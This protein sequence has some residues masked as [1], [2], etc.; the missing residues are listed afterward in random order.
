MKPEVDIEHITFEF[1][2]EELTLQIVEQATPGW[3]I[4][5]LVI[6]CTVSHIVVL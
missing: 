6:P 4:E 2:K 5:P 1:A 3:I